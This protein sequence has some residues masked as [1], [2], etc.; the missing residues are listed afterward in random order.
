MFHM[1]IFRNVIWVNKCRNLSG[2]KYFYIAVN[3]AKPNPN[4]NPIPKIRNYFFPY[5]LNDI[6]RGNIIRFFF[7]QLVRK[8]RGNNYLPQKGKVRENN[9]CLT[10]LVILAKLS[11]FRQIFP[12]IN[13]R[14]MK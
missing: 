3:I 6:T 1:P 14:L 10:A 8:Y 13:H 9:S 7:Y 12:H 5:C 11:L 2:G 4:P